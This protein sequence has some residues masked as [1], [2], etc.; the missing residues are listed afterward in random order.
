MLNCWLS[1][2]VV[3]MCRTSRCAC[4]LKNVARAFLTR[5]TGYQTFYV[6]TKSIQQELEMLRV[7]IYEQEIRF[8]EYELQLVRTGT[9]TCHIFIR[10]VTNR[11]LLL[12]T[13]VQRENQES[14]GFLADQVNK[15]PSFYPVQPADAVV[16]VPMGLPPW[17]LVAAKMVWAQ[18]DGDHDGKLTCDELHQLKV[19][20][21]AARSSW[22]PR[23]TITCDRINCER[24]TTMSMKFCRITQQSP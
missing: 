12:T 18:F 21:L 8:R 5:Y 24:I 11:P 13:S 16:P 19:S 20:L 3:D 9:S 17:S 1:R 10:R 15:L 23:L 2:K 4:Q 22:M 14:L 7:T 6:E